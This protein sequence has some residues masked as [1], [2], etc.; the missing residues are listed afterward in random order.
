MQKLPPK[1]AWLFAIA[2]WSGTVGRA[3][4]I[5]PPAGSL[6][7]QEPAR[8]EYG[9]SEPTTIGIRPVD[10]GDYWQRLERAEAQIAE[11]QAQNQSLR[12]SQSPILQ[13]GFNPLHLAP[14]FT[15][16]DPEIGIIREQTSSTSGLMELPTDLS[17]PEAPKPK[18]WYDKLSIRGYVQVRINELTRLDEGSTRPQYVG[19]RSVSDNQNFLIRRARVI[20]SGDVHE[21]LYVYLQPD[22][23]VGLSSVTTESNQFAQIRDWYGDFYLD[24]EKEYRIRVGQSKVP[25]GW[26][27]MQSSSNRLPLDRA[28][29]LN[30]A[31]R[32]ERDLGIY[33]FYTPTWAQ[34]FFKEVLEKGY[35]GSGNYG[36]FSAGIYNGQ[37]GSL[38]E[39]NDD[40]H[41]FSRLTLPL[42]LENGQHVEF[43]IQGYTGEYA[44]IGS[45]IDPDGAGGAGP[46]TPEGTVAVSGAGIGA[47]AASDRDGWNDRRIAGTF[48][49]Y[50]Q[51]FGFQTEWTV[52]RGPALNAAQTA[53]E[54]RSLYGGY[55][56]LLYK[57]DTECWGTWFPYVRYS[58]FKGGYKSERNAP[59]SRIDEWEFGTE[60]QINPSAELTLAYLITDRTNTVANSAAGSLSYGQFDGQVIRLQ[61]QLNY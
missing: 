9:R 57:L 18:K 30:S 36:L 59:F 31:V 54:E 34:D 32:N 19:D 4:E 39:I 61:F 47:N 5:S 22:F 56:M 35:K 26:E 27:N 17:K 24:D 58:Y 43:A 21:R 1:W 38:N 44:V 25:Y 45:T 13:T 49:W 53:I 2:L 29:S 55:A 23:A 52:G 11:L 16:H 14:L 51:P 60:W 3:E 28:D 42:I 33:F 8:L 50:P 7:G 48:V 37:G 12:E 6:S 46:A 15:A 20:L 41:F 10:P 40:V